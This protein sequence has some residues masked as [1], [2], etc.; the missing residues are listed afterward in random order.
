P[1]IVNVTNST[2]IRLED[3][4]NKTCYFRLQ[5]SEGYK[6]EVFVASLFAG[7]DQRPILGHCDK[8]NALEAR[9][10]KDKGA[11]G[12][13]FCGPLSSHYIVS[14]DNVTDFKYTGNHTD[15]A[16]SLLVRRVNSTFEQADVIDPK[17]IID[18]SEDYDEHL[19]DEFTPKIVNDTK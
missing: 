12:A 16:I 6:I 3:Y 19:L 9:Y 4:G 2:F 15:D 5:T 18:T 17:I 13:L 11:T 7:A 1:K 8:K 10:Y 14:R